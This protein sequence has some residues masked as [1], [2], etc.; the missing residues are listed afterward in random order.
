LKEFLGGLLMNLLGEKG[1]VAR[2][3]KIGCT[4]YLTKPVKPNL[5][6]DCTIKNYI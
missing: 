6:Y 4:A 2:L 5:L 1:D 3:R